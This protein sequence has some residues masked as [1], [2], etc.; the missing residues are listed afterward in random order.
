MDEGNES[1]WKGVEREKE[2]MKLKRDKGS[3][4]KGVMI[5]GG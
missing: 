5:T 2:W 4:L 3:G 1:D